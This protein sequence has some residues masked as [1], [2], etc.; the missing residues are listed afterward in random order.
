MRYQSEP[1]SNFETREEELELRELLSEPDGFERYAKEKMPEFIQVVRDYEGFVRD[2][3]MTP[4]VEPHELVRVDDEVFVVYS[5][6]I[7]GMAG[8]IARNGEAQTLHVKAKTIK[9]SFFPMTTPRI[10]ISQWDLDTQPYDLVKRTQE[11]CGQEMAKKEDLRFLRIADL[12]L[13]ANAGQVTSQAEDKIT[14]AGLIA[15]KKIFSRNNVTF[16]TYLMNPATYDDFLLWG[17]DDLDDYSQ[18]TVLET[19][20]LP[21]LWNGVKIVSGIIVPEDKVYGLAPKEIVGRMPILRDL[22]IDNQRN[23]ETYDREVMAFQHVG[24]FIHSHLVVA[25]L[26]LGTP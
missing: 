13:G 6:D 22:T 10:T 2:V 3:I 5:K 7:D 11:K 9:V 26:D 23:P 18:K 12:L 24:M 1:R 14:K 20:E 25:R 21:T 4:P 16:S 17:E 15:V 19:G 8:Y